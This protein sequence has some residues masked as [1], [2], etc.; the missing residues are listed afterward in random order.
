MKRYFLFSLLAIAL[1]GC[2]TL[3]SD[4]RRQAFE[5]ENAVYLG[6]TYDD[7]VRGKGVPTG[8]ATLSDGSKVAEYYRSQVEIVGG[9]YLTYPTSSYIRNANGGGGSWIEINQT[10]AL[11][12][13]AL[14]K[15][16]KIDFLISP[17]NQ[18]ESWKYEGK[19]CF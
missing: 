3:S 14:N 12:I 7:L 13:R 5:A 1:T 8:N 15:I 18:L 6:K 4:A 9:G 17:G 2:G 16:C 10:R 11:P 19:G